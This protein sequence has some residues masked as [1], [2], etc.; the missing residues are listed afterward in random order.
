M[1]RGDHTGSMGQGPATGR[2]LGLCAGF[3]S[4]GFTKEAGG[5]MGR[6]F[7]FGRGR[8]MGMALGRGWKFAGASSRSFAGN[9]R[10]PSI[11]KEDE[12]K[13]IFESPLLPPSYSQ[14]DTVIPN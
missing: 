13:L 10:M 14:P 8:G 5:G 2:G 4:P 7:G 1:P 9:S 12:V 6:G 3:D 11:S